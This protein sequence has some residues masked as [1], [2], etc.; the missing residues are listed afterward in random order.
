M[1][2]FFAGL[3]SMLSMDLDRMDLGSVARQFIQDEIIPKL[4]K[5]LDMA[6]TDNQKERLENLIVA[7]GKCVDPRS[8]ES[9]EFN[10]LAVTVIKSVVRQFGQEDRD[11]M[12]DMSQQ[13]AMD[14]F[15]PLPGGEDELRDTLRRLNE[16]EGPYALKKIWMSAIDKRVKYHLRQIQRKEQERTVQLNK[17]DEGVEELNPLESV[18]GHANI[19]EDDVEQVIGDL[20][21]YMHRRLRNPKFVAM[22]DIWFDLVQEKG[23]SVDM[24]RDVYPVL[25]D[26][27][28][29]GTYNAMM[30]QWKDNVAR[31]AFNFLTKELGQKMA[32]QI[33]KI[34]HLSSVDALAHVEFRRRMAAWVLGGVIR[35]MIE[36]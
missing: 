31:E 24:K 5:K 9:K 14:F 3:R 2:L 32:P 1:N 7:Y 34:L 36:A 20:S 6:S 23:P 30:E 25:A 8:Q 15:K 16:E 17:D 11:L 12:E 35:A 10:S 4:Q 21:E 27:G 29:A 28:F 26:K 13:L 33:K 18:P 19:N 22:F